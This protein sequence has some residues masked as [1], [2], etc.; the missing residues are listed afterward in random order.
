[1]QALRRPFCRM[2]VLTL[3]S[4]SI[5]A[6][7]R[8]LKYTTTTPPSW[9]T[10][11]SETASL[12]PYVPTPPMA[13]NILLDN[14]L[15]I[16]TE[17]GSSRY[18]AHIELGCGEGNL[19]AAALSRGFEKSFGYDSDERVLKIAISKLPE[20]QFQLCDL[21]QS[22]NTIVEKVK[23]LVTGG[24]SIIMTMYFVEDGLEKIRESILE[25]TIKHADI[26]TIGYE[27]PGWEE[28]GGVVGGNVLG[29][30]WFV[31]SRR[32]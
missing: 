24:D 5:P 12:S 27:V 29:V 17:N 4:R 15:Q 7:V 26:V 31:Y 19:N 32:K 9:D 3:G 28:R 22:P 23:G 1:M 13:A 25:E 20:A 10:Y 14:L 6:P 21:T 11:I 18:T 30:E 2:H 8:N 16:Q